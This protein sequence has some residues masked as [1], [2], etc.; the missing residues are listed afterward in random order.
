MSSHKLMMQ[1]TNL[2]DALLE[3]LPDFAAQHSLDPVVDALADLI[4]PNLLTFGEVQW[5][6]HFLRSTLDFMDAKAEIRVLQ[7]LH[8]FIDQHANPAVAD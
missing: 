5:F 3:K 1:R 7:G 8:T 6:Q 2:Y 4:E